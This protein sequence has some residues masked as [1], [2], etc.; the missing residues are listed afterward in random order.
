MKTIGIPISHVYKKYTV[1]PG[2][3]I[4]AV[5]AVIY[6]I[7]D[8]IAVFGRS[9]DGLKLGELIYWSRL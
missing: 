2:V 7:K 6:L 8:D 9:T 5:Y 4:N 1:H 3:D